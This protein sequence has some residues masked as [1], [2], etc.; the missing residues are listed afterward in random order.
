LLALPVRKP[1]IAVNKELMAIAAFGR[2]ATR[3]KR[4]I[5]P[6]TISN[7]IMPIMIFPQVSILW[8]IKRHF[9]RSFNI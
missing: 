1:A 7:G 4:A 5:M 9:L 2:M 6:T 8:K 3:M